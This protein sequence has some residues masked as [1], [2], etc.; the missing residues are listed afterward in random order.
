MAVER[1]YFYCVPSEGEG[2][3]PY[4]H[5][6]VALA[7]GLRELGVECISNVDYWPLDP[8]R[9]RF[10]LRHDPT[11]GPDDCALV[12]VSD[13]WFR[14]GRS[15]PEA[16]GRRHASCW[17]ALDRDD[18]T[19]LRSLEPSFRAFDFILRTHYNAA[20]RYRDNFVPWAYGLSERIVNATSGNGASAPRRWEMLANW[21]HTAHPHSLRLDVE[22]N[23]LPRLAE[24]LPVNRAHE[25]LDHAPRQPAEQMWWRETG[26]RHWPAYYERLRS[27]AACACF[28]GNFVTPWPL[29][30]ESLL[31][32]GLKAV[33]AASRMRTHL[34]AQFDSWR[35]WES[36]AAGCA[37][38]HVD[39][40]R[41]GCILPVMPVNWTHYVGLDLDRCDDAIERLRADPSIVTRIGAAGREWALANYGPAATA[42]RLLD[43]AGGAA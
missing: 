40:E 2:A 25:D 43:L 23:A 20:T 29:A 4:Q 39:L 36:W 11:A 22:R 28:G 38:F 14:T 8:G 3:V 21:R 34:I 12:I 18:G 27:S 41:Y 35:L 1:A 9:T 33:L 10:L 37:T 32:R 6:V 15:F 17:I 31:S 13:D 30:K 16:L 5:L 42:Q 24:L 26:R 19:R 7:E